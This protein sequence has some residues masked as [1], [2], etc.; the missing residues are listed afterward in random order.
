MW[1]G[2]SQSDGEAFTQEEQRDCCYVFP[3]CLLSLGRSQ[4]DM[5]L[6]YVGQKHIVGAHSKSRGREGGPWP[7]PVFTLTHTTLRMK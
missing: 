7:H 5:A 4:A 1:G 2:G 3:G 6:V